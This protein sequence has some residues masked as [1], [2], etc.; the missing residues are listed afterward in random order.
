[1][2]S[3]LVA[4]LLLSGT[5]AASATTV[6]IDLP[7]EE[8]PQTEKVSYACGDKT[9]AATYINTTGNQFAVLELGDATVVV[10]TVMSGSG[11]RY[12][13]QHYEWWTKGD[14]ATL[15]DLMQDPQKPIECNLSK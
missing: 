6:T 12:V 10:V 13:G 9:V 5:A 7:G 15:T 3:P 4:L 1:M 2:R 8:T 11:A 14:T